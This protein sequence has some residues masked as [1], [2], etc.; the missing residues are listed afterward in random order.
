MSKIE[1]EIQNII[2]TRHDNAVRVADE[3]LRI[4]LENDEIKKMYDD[5]NSLKFE[6]AKSLYEKKDT[7]K[8]IKKY[9]TTRNKLHTTLKENNFDKNTLKPNYTCKKCN[10]TGV[11]DNKRCVCFNKLLNKH[12]LTLSG[13]NKNL[14]SFDK[15]DY[16]VYNEKT[17]DNVRIIVKTMQEIVKKYPNTTKNMLNIFGKVGVGKTYLSECFVNFAIKNNLYTVYTTSYNL[18]QDMLNYHL[19][20]INQ[21]SDILD[22]Y[23]NSDILCI[24]DLGTENILKNVTVEYLYLILNERQQ[25]GKFTLITTNLMPNQIIEIYDERIFSRLINKEKNIIINLEG[26]DLR[27]KK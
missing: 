26:D 23:I 4:V 5:C 10:D 21:K 17:A 1:K 7:T 24:D 13:I 14:P 3:N 11:S 18:N 2:D 22:K 12:L 9:N 16:S 25:K 27:L 20:P 19:A 6:I 15:I 8:L